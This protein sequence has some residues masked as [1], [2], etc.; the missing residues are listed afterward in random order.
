VTSSPD[1]L[2]EFISRVS[3]VPPSYETAEEW[4]WAAGED[5]VSDDT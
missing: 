4:R 3:D 1:V 5:I 2:T